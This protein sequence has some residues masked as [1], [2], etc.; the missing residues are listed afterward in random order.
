MTAWQNEKAS[1]EYK[2][3]MQISERLTEE[4]RALKKAAHTARQDLLRGAK[5]NAAILRGSRVWDHLSHW[6]KELLEDFN[7]GKLTRARD[8]CDAAFGWSKQM[9][10]AAGSAVS[11]MVR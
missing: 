10:S 1:D 7:S 9:R 3:R 11:R 5:L 8:D 4:R 6:E 2:K